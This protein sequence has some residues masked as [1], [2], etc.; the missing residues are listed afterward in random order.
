M[1]FTVVGPTAGNDNEFPNASRFDVE[2]GL[3]V[4]R[5]AGAP[6]L[7]HAEL[8]SHVDVQ[9][10]GRRSKHPLQLRRIKPANSC[11][12]AV[13]VRSRLDMPAC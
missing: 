11:L 3:A 4:L 2:A 9:V 8:V 6:L 5:Q 12:A 13:T 7:A 1:L 10:R